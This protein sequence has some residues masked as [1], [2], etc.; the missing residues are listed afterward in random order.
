MGY[1]NLPPFAAMTRMFALSTLLVLFSISTGKVMSKDQ[2]KHT[3]ESLGG[4]V[5]TNP[6]TG[7]VSE[8]RM[9]QCMT[10]RDRDLA[11][12]NTYELLTDLSLEG[13]SINGTGF[14]TLT[15]LK[16]VQWLNL[17]DTK[18]TDEGLREIA[19]LKSLTHLPIGRTEITDAGIQ[20]LSGMPNLLYLGLRGTKISNHGIRT[21]CSLPKLIELNLR[22]T[23]ITDKCIKHLTGIRSLRKVWLG[24]TGITPKGIEQL[25]RASPNCEI[26][27]E[28]N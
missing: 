27:L 17:W 28:A 8:I 3:V 4:T 15:K 23:R 6:L 20:H 22:N 1:L 10:L 16:N 25:R 24:E 11:I 5:V 21:L 12:L 18:I 2:E 19:R 13:T 9:N 14:S 7:T 26:N